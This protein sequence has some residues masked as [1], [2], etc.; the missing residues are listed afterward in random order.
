MPYLSSTNKLHNFII[1]GRCDYKDGPYDVTIPVDVTTFNYSLPILNDD[2]YEIDETFSVV[3][4]SSDHSQIKINRA[5]RADVT[6]IDDE[7][8]E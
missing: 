1:T 6:I 8:R 4:A 2:V 7:E 5:D 3:I